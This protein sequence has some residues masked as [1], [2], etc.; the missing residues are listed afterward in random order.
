MSHIPDPILEGLTRGWKVLGG[1]LGPAPEK[2]VCDVAIV[3]SGAGAG[4]TA[5]LLARAG[6]QVVMI[7]EGPLKSSSDFRQRESD[8]YPQLYQESA[9]RKTEDK[10]INILQGRCVG[11]STTV[12]WTSSFR[13]PAPTLQFWQDRFGLADYSVEALA[14]YFAQ[15]EQ[16]LN[17]LPWLTAPNEN[18]DL[19]R[20]GAARLGIQAA[21]ISRNVK[22]C[23][24]LGSCGLGCPTNAKQSMLVTTIPAALDRG[25]QLLTEM[26]VEKF[27][28]ANGKV[29]ALYC[30]RV[31]PNGAPDPATSAQMATKIIAKHFVLAGGAIN[32][33]AVLLRSNAPDPH[34][35]LGTRTF[36]HPV[37]MSSG[38]FEQ[39]VQAWSGA[40]QTI[41]TDHFLDTQAIDGP[42]GYK[43]EAPPLHPIIFASTVP[44]FGQRQQ[45]L[46]ERFPHNHTLLALLRDGFHDQS[47][48][49]KVKL[50]ADGSAVLDYP[51]TDYVMDGARRALLSMLEIQFAA[52]ARQVLPLHEMAH[53]YTSWGEARDAVNA[54]PMKPLLTKVVS[55]HVMGGCGLGGEEKRGVTRPDGVH[56]QLDNLSVHDGSIF[57]T[58]IGAN[59]QLS[60]YGTVNRLAQGL[61]KRLTGRDV[62]LA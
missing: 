37:V 41:Y 23:W 32:S 24:S 52:G 30:R 46:L 43:L 6:L 31:M 7:E 19:L 50:R 45:A 28:L 27:E 51:L 16:R 1:A 61:V 53:P 5:E 56:W 18:N 35:L 12:N 8:A 36:L 21:A 60:I 44:G 47:R 59:P 20:R 2:I 40:P 62:A 15:A 14:P 29:I 42:I 17:I 55:A 3:G 49:G 48:G 9:A 34:G 39:K 58:S 54:L 10:A 57:P 25:A 11:G 33:P 13:T 4:I 26:R 38:V 22:G